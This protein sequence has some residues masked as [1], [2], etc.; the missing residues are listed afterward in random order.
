M[1]SAQEFQEIKARVERATPGPW[2]FK[3]ADAL[4]PGVGYDKG[5][6]FKRLAT[7]VRCDDAKFAAHARTDLPR[8]I[9]AYEEE[10]KENQTMR[11]N[12]KAWPEMRR[13][14]YD[15]GFTSAQLLA[16]G[17]SAK[18][19]E[20]QAIIEMLE[21]LR[22]KAR[23]YHEIEKQV[24]SVDSPTCKIWAGHVGALSDA[25]TLIKQRDL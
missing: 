21:A 9:E 13:L 18:R 1:L 17:G 10:L 7:F 24:A 20:R 8:L 15:A 6:F 4:D 22:T 14:S 16:D 12:L 11:E 5:G 2:R 23:I 3:D 25:I 19:E